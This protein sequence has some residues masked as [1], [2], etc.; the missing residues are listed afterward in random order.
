MEF[1]D[2]AQRLISDYARG[3]ENEIRNLSVNLNSEYLSMIVFDVKHYVSF[4]SVKN[5]MKR[6]SIKVEV[7]DVKSALKEFGDPKKLVKSHFKNAEKC[8]TSQRITLDDLE[9][10]KEV[11]KDVE[12]PMVLDAGCGWGR[13]SKKLKDY[14]IRNLNIVG[15]DVDKP[16]LQYGRLVEGT[17]VFIRAAIENLPLR[18]QVFNM[19]VAGGVI[20]EVKS[21]KG[22]EKAIKE[23][24]RVLRPKGVLYI[25]DVFT[26]RI[27][28]ALTFI[29]QHLTHKVEWIPKKEGI[30]RL[31]MESGFEPIS[32]RKGSSLLC[33]LVTVHTIIV[34]KGF[35][36]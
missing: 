13:L 33:G 20:H 36:E 35:K 17:A 7:T 30:E 23:F 10:I 18:D 16:S 1:T 24:Y 3:I 2:E 8:L 34:K 6:G 11:L 29:L 28:S 5:A 27:V 12:M 14:C 19:V 21:T 32:I 31:L 22:R 4:F 15:V 25:V 9:I 26:N